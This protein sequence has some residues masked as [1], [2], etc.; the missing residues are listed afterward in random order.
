MSWRVVTVSGLSKL[1]YKM[2]YL[3]VRNRES[4]KRVHLSEISVLMLESTSV[5][6]TAYLLCELHQHKIDVIFCDEKRLPYAMMSS[7][8]GSHNTALKYRYQALWSQEIKD[9]IW[10]ELVRAKMRGQF[11]LLPHE[12]E[13]ER[14]LLD[15]YIRDIL[16]GDRTNREGHAAKVYFNAL[17]GM[18]FVRSG[19]D[20]V[21][22]SL[23]YGYSVLLS[24]FAR[25]ITLNG[26]CTQLGIFHDNM[27][28]HL[29]LACDFMEPFRVFV[30]KRVLSLKPQK[31]EHDEKVYLIN[32]L[33]QQVFLGGREEYM[34]NA[35]REYVKSVFRA[36]EE[37][38]ISL[39]RF[40]AYEL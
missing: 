40:P 5:S 19:E 4:T 12:K 32:T 25:E 38:N 22:A 26:Y 27:F 1:D 6:M 23:N 34:I 3:I 28:N 14:Q 37:Q 33:N 9:R 8:R 21:N 31:L 39:I 16:P 35:I 18:E 13:R 36:L 11:A 20:S 7:L 24:V 30:D 29:N 2:D 15:G 17:F 10:A